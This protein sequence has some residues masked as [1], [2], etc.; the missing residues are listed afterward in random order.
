M[1]I[2]LFELL[3]ELSPDVA[4]ELGINPRE[5]A[6]WVA[7]GT[8]GL[9]V[10]E[11]FLLADQLEKTA[12]KIAKAAA[13]GQAP[14]GSPPVNGTTM[15]AGPGSGPTLPDAPRPKGAPPIVT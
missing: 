8:V 1:T 11:L 12:E 2:G 13:Q 6:I 15:Q 5:Y 14:A 10:T 7:F 4:S 3:L 9:H